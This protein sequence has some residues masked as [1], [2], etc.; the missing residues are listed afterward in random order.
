MVK[1]KERGDCVG[2]NNKGLPLIYGLRVDLNKNLEFQKI[3]DFKLDDGDKLVY[4]DFNCSFTCPQSFVFLK[5]K[6]TKSFEHEEYRIEPRMVT[7]IV[8]LEPNYT[9]KLVKVVNKSNNVFFAFIVFK[10]D[11]GS[12][13]IDSIIMD[14]DNAINNDISKIK[15]IFG[16]YGTIALYEDD[17]D[18]VIK[19]IKTAF[20]RRVTIYTAGD[21]IDFIRAAKLCKIDNVAPF[22]CAKTLNKFALFNDG[23]FDYIIKDISIEDNMV[24]VIRVDGIIRTKMYMSDIKLGNFHIS[25]DYRTVEFYKAVDNTGDTGITVAYDYENLADSTE[26][27]IRDVYC[28]NVKTGNIKSGCEDNITCIYDKLGTVPL[29]DTNICR[30]T[31]LIAYLCMHD[32]TMHPTALALYAMYEHVEEKKYR[33]GR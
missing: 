16:D 12:K 14:T 4:A 5:V 33:D 24:D 30:N 9:I 22:K 27:F 19:Y 32:M 13:V 20:R 25:E 21:A 23:A 6:D 31:A 2:K 8:W 28:I 15:Y 17:Y 29:S 1:N 3:N 26:K 7:D 10:H 18:D 11:N